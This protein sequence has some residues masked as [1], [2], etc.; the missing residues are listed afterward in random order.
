MWSGVEVA[1]ITRSISAGESPASSRAAIAARVPSTEVVSSARAM[2]RWR[3]PVR[4]TIHS[5]EVSIPRSA[6]SVFVTTV[7]G[8]YAPQPTTTERA[9]AIRSVPFSLLCPAYF[10]TKP[11]SSPAATAGVCSSISRIVRIRS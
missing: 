3:M 1:Q 9:C 8:R 7:S 11:V 2:W 10:S 5:S 4:W 6:R